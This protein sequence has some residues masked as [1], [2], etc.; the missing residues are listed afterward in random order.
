[1]A[2]RDSSSEIT[3]Q[4]SRPSR[5]V[6]Q[7][8]WEGV[9]QL[10][11]AMLVPG[12]STTTGRPAASDAVAQAAFAGSTPIASAGGVWWQAKRIAADAKAP[13]PIWQST[14]S[15]GSPACSAASAKIVEY[16]SETHCETGS[17]AS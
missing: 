4:P 12:A 11:P 2:A 13:T 5:S 15:K 6:G 17:D 16:P 3:T 10:S 7:A 14:T 9:A 8:V 1:M